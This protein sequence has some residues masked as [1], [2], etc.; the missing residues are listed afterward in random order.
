MLANYTSDFSSMGKQGIKWEIPHHNLAIL[1]PTDMSLSNGEIRL[2]PVVGQ[3]PLC[4]QNK[5]QDEKESPY[6]DTV[7]HFELGEAFS[8]PEKT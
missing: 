6:Q 5:E 2:H 7:L 4:Q 8:S 3:F 1:E